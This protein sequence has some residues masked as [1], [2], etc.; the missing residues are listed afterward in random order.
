MAINILVVDD[1]QDNRELLVAICQRMK[2]GDI[3]VI[4]AANGVQALELAFRHT[5]ALILLDLMMPGLSGCELCSIIKNN[6]QLQGAHIIMLT[7]AD[8]TDHRVRA[9]NA[10]ADRFMPKP[11][12][13]ILLTDSIRQALE[14]LISA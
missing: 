10:G 6:P 2:L 9:Q 11:F 3:H 14:P 7:A 13:I 1:N 4:E 5:P 8:S 12:D